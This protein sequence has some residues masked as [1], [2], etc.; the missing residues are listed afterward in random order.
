MKVLIVDDDQDKVATLKTHL[1]EL[2]VQDSDVSVAYHAAQ[3]RKLL[4]GTAFDIMLLDVLLPLREEDDKPS[5]TT[6][7]ELL[8]QIVEDRDYNQP[9]YIIGVTADLNALAQHENDFKRLTS[10]IIEVTP[11][12]NDWKSTIKHYLSVCR[13]AKDAESTYDYDVCVLTALR[14]PELKAVLATWKPDIEG[15]DL[16]TRSVKFSSGFVNCGTTTKKVAFA[17]LSQMGLVSATHTTE[18][19]LQKFKP[20]VLI[21]TGICGGFSDHVNIGDV[22]VADKS[23]DWQA[24]KWTE[25]QVLLSAPDQKEAA[26]D[27]IAIVPNIESKLND[28]QSNFQGNT[29]NIRPKLIIDPMVSGS[30]VVASTDIQKAFRDQH[31]KMAAVDMECYGMYYA[32]AV[33]TAPTPKTICIKSVSDLADREK[34]DNFQNYCSYM[35]ACVALELIKSLR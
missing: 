10:Q 28:F 32:A 9:K 29:P 30:S 2:D 33:T 17:H 21:M 18:A 8:R 26:S 25:N 7:V 34:S 11:F 1:V 23:W 31:R 20:R 5:G 16:L 19:L 6:S 13:G 15:S 35:S 22:V 4:N 14:D 12:L 24:G 27:L 3:A